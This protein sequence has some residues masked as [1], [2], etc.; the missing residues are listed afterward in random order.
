[1]KCSDGQL[2]DKVT[3]S[4]AIQCLIE[5]W[6]LAAYFIDRND[7]QQIIEQL[8]AVVNCSNVM[9]HS[10]RSAALACLSPFIREY[11]GW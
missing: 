3:L 8:Y 9:T 2:L 6:R 7:V 4:T 10:Q 5:Y 1:M 11:G